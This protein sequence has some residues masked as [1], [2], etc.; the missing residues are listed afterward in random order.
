[1]VIGTDC[2]SSCNSNYHAI[3]ATVAP[4]KEVRKY[5]KQNKGYR[6]LELWCLTPHSTIFSEIKAVSFI[7]GGQKK[8]KK[9]GV[10]ITLICHAMSLTILTAVV[11]LFVCALVEWKQICACFVYCLFIYYVYG[12]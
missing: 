2:I 9:S 7:S 11:H 1:M 5:I 10:L 3:T 8:T 12:L 6:G 4:Y